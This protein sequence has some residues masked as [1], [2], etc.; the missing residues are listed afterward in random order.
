MASP[1]GKLR[2]RGAPHS[3][4]H[5]FSETSLP[6]KGGAC[7]APFLPPTCVTRETATDVFAGLSVHPVPAMCWASRLQ[8]AMKQNPDISAKSKVS[9][10]VHGVLLTLTRASGSV[11]PPR[12]APVA[13]NPLSCEIVCDRPGPEAPAFSSQ[14]VSQCSRLGGCS[15]PAP[16]S[17]RGR[18]S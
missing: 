18:C 17:P 14:E 7:P 16:P 12:A 13:S 2:Q 8:N 5:P 9:P 11:S 1:V 10:E 4:M 3:L 15:P 6:T